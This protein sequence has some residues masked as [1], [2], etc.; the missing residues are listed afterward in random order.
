M[1]KNPER[2][3]KRS[4]LLIALVLFI[5]IPISLIALGLLLWFGREAFGSRELKSRIAK[6]TRQGFPV[7]NATVETFYKDRT[8]P[9]N[10]NAWLAVIGTIN[11]AEFA[12]SGN[13]VPLVG[14]AGG[15]L[16]T[17]LDSVWQEEQIARDFLLKWKPLISEISRLSI[18]AKPV[19]FP[20]ST[21][22]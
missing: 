19:R 17:E 22:P 1:N 6:V 13:R 16:P 5:G 12:A 3:S 8:D 2:A 20:A 7:D 11:S 18:D 10:T 9:A 14:A 4:C 21:A 15:E